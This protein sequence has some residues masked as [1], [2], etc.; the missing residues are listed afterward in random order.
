MGRR[1]GTG[2]GRYRELMRR[3]F[4]GYTQRRGVTPRA[5]ALQ[6]KPRGAGAAKSGANT[7]GIGCTHPS[8]PLFTQTGREQEVAN[9][10]K[11]FSYSNNVFAFL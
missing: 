1:G 2:V 5:L 7:T 10:N 11:L 4:G 9:W 8:H 3:G 6:L